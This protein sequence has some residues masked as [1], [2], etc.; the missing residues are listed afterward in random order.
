[1]PI[2]EQSLSVFERI[3]LATDGTVTDL[4]A[5]YSGEEIRVKK[6]HQAIVPSQASPELACGN[7]ARLLNRRIL[8]AGAVRNYLYAESL[9]VFE[10]F[11]ASLQERLLHTD[12]PIGL[13]WKE[14]RLE[15][16]REV[17]AKSIEPGAAIGQYFDLPP[18]AEFV[19]RTYLIHHGGRPL[20]AITEKW[21]LGVF[22]NPRI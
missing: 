9:F 2:N 21:P 18:Q 14:A 17:I 15:T 3:L 13:L 19:S 10:R 7:D 16:Y 12:T 5:L 20:G 11:S 4:I 1:M 6:L 8:L 22:R